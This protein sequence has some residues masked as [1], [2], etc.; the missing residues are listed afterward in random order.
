M[1]PNMLNYASIT[2]T[3]TSLYFAGAGF[4]LPHL[5]MIVIDNAHN[6]KEEQ[7]QANEKYFMPNISR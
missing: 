3:L 5:F 4:S 2:T 6:T 1:I 7:M